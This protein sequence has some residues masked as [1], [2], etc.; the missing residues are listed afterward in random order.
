MTTTPLPTR[1]HLVDILPPGAFVIELGV[2]AGKFAAEMLGRHPSITYLGI[3]R[4]ADHHNEAEMRA[5]HSLLDGFGN[6]YTL[7]RKTFREWLPYESSSSADMIYIDGYAHTGQE[8]GE[9]LRDWWPVLKPGGIFAGHDYDAREYPQTVNAVDAFVHFH[10]L[11]LHLTGE[12]RLPSW[13]LRKPR[14]PVS[15]Q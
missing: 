5:A 12:N 14:D 6:R 15:G 8:R 3:D 10:G 4:W 2:A 9:T 13:W 1:V 7:V 11:E